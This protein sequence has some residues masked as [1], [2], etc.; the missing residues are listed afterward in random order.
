MLERLY[1][2]VTD[3]PVIIQGAL[4]SALFA[5]IVYVGQRIFSVVQLRFS[6]LSKERRRTY[7]LEQQ[8]KYNVLSTK[9]LPN[10]GAL[11][12]LLLY[13]ASRSLFKALIWLTSGLIFGSVDSTLGLVGY[14]GCI[15]YLLLGLSAVTGPE[16]VED[17]EAKLEEIRN[18][19]AKLDE[20]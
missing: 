13:R 20:A 10:R 15:Y 5:S 2:A 8:I 6:A 3:L 9:G 1:S 11:V 7:L 16:P 19:L 4:G 18:E 12:S 14:F 17:N